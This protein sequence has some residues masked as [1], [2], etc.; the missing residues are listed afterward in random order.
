MMGTHHHHPMAVP[1]AGKELRQA[2]ITIITPE[3][4]MKGITT[5]NIQMFISITI[6][7][8]MMNA[9]HGIKKHVL[10]VVYVTMYLMSA[11]RE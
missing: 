4:T 7:L 11:G 10:L 8:L 9:N 1:I 2:L 3:A 6:M 5:L